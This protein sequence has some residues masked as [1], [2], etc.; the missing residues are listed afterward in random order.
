MKFKVRIIM[1]R[2]FCIYFLYK[3]IRYLEQVFR[4]FMNEVPGIEGNVFP[5][6]C[7]GSIGNEKTMLGI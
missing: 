1:K 2:N 7:F 4:N 3:S 5:R 6:Q